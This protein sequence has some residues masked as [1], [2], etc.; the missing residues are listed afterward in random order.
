MPA[1]KAGDAGCLVGGRDG[2]LVEGGEGRTLER[3]TFEALVVVDGAVANGLHLEHPRDRLEVW[4][5]DGL[6]DGLDFIIAMSI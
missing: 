2:Y 3:G 6:C 1:I 5:E 4:M